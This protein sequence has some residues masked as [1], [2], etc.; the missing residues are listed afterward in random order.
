[1][2]FPGNVLHDEIFE[3]NRSENY[4]QTSDK[5]KK[6]THNPT[7]RNEAS[8]TVFR[9]FVYRFAVLSNMFFLRCQLIHCNIVIH[10]SLVQCAYS[11]AAMMTADSNTLR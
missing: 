5:L 6:N 8:L 1:M 9:F 4:F 2:S 3:T 10:C 11:E 7:V